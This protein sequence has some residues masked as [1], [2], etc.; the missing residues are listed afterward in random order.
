M[1]G[2]GIR[3]LVPSMDSMLELWV[4][5]DIVCSASDSRP[6]SV[7][8]SATRVLLGTQGAVLHQIVVL[9]VGVVLL[10]KVSELGKK[11]CL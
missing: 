8:V 4:S 9:V 3:S 11:T 7:S 2:E 1:V 10:I 5:I 6:P